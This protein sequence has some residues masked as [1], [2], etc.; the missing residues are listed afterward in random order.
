MHHN[1]S[2]SEHSW[3]PGRLF[4]FGLALTLLATWIPFVP[5]W[6]TF[7]HMWRVELAASLF[8]FATLS[9]LF[10]R[11]RSLNFIA[12]LSRQELWLIVFPMLAFIG[13]SAISITWAPSWKSAMHHTLVWSEYLIFYLLVR[14]LVDHDDNAGK[15]LRT[16]ATV[17]VLFALPALVEFTAA[18]ITGDSASFRARFAKYGE[19][20]LTMLPL[21]LVVVLRSSGRRFQAGLAAVVAMWLLIYCTAGR[22]NIFLFV[23]LVAAIGM[24]VVAFSKRH[25]YR[26]RLAIVLLTVAAAPVPFYLLSLAAGD[27]EVPIV[28]R[29][30]DTSGNAYSNGF[31]QLMNRVSLEML[32]AAPMNGVGAD[33]Y[34]F[35]FND[36]RARYGAQNP[37]DKNL[38]YGEVG[39]VGQAHNEYLQ[40]AA[41][42][43]VVGFAIF[44]WFLTG[45]G[46]L[47]WKSV[48]ELGRGSLLPFAA[49]LGLALFLA[50]SAVSSYSFRLVQNGFVFFVVLAIAAKMLLKPAPEEVAQ[51]RRVWTRPALA[52][53]LAACLLL[54]VYS[55]IRVSSVIVTEKANWTMAL[56]EAAPLYRTAMALDDENPDVRNNFGKRYFRTERYAEAIPLLS[57]SIR[58]GRAESTDFSY[59]ATCQSLTGDSASA[60]KTMKEAAALYPR[61]PFVLTRYAGILQQNGKINDAGLNLDRAIELDRPAA[62]TWWAMINRGSQTAS[63]LAFSRKDHLPIMDLQPTASIYAVLDERG[64]LHP[65]EK[66]IFKR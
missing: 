25:R 27:P 8:L 64:I 65:E 53:G 29:F 39:I 60:E 20:I 40:I 50:S 7:I 35:Q 30:A 48:R 49:T 45:L 46:Y 51:V 15:L 57:E 13:W 1:V 16:L 41:E 23:M 31:R 26:R 42:L 9:Y 61:S 52:A 22:V 28:A 11:S 44:A 19:Q 33:N 21:L 66:S 10:V 12:D 4:Y 55:L 54:A 3:K 5:A 58:I 2:T 32:R 63:D 38:V 34:G 14:Y 36:Y 62:N 56:D 6:Y 47:G 24:A 43:G 18:A 17:L 37:D 59:L